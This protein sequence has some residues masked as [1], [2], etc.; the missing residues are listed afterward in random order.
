MQITIKRVGRSVM[1]KIKM[2]SKEIFVESKR[3][4]ILCGLLGIDIIPVP[5]IFA[6]KIG[7]F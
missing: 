6:K 3:K 7:T 4:E 1:L 2:A 5:L